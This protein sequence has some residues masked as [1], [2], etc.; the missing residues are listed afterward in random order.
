MGIG[1]T[2]GGW[3]KDMDRFRGRV[4][5]YIRLRGAIGVGLELGVRL[6]LWIR[7]KNKCI[8]RES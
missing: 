8:L 2:I 7:K 6:R 1:L 5:G 4:R 3:V